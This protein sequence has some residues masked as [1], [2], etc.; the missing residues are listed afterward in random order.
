MKPDAVVS[1]FFSSAAAAKVKLIENEKRGNCQSDSSVSIS[2]VIE[3]DL[4]TAKPDASVGPGNEDASV[5]AENGNECKEKKKKH[6]KKRS[7]GSNGEEDPESKRLRRL[8]KKMSKKEKKEK[9]E[10]KNK[11]DYV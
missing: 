4:S 3:S 11:T 8:E 2:P 6:K 1:E 7:D 5:K 9:K 10:E